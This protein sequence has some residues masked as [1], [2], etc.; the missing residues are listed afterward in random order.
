MD[1]KSGSSK[2]GVRR[3]RP[4][5]VVFVDYDNT[6]HR[7]DAYISAQGI[8]SSVPGVQLFEFAEILEHALQPY[9]HVKLVISSDWVR[10][11]GFEKARNALPLPSLRE[12]VIGSTHSEDI[13]RPAFSTLS[14]GEQIRR[15]VV[16]HKL[17]SWL[18]IDD[19]MDGFDPYPEQLVRCQ[20]GVGLGDIDVQRRLAHRLYATFY[21]AWDWG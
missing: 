12:R 4:P 8:M 19:R 13:N 18:A 21:V 9:P 3:L 7:G 6:L 5:D 10:V 17:K 2:R 20:A 15:Y 1:T 14:R 16:G 11:L